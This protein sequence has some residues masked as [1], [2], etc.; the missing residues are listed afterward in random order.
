MKAMILAAGKGTRL[1]TI[2]DTMPKAL[3]DIN[4][5]SALQ[6]AVEKCVSYGFN[7]IIVNVHHFADLVEDEAARLRKLG[8]SIRLSDERE[9]L[10]DTGGGLF[11]ARNFFDNTPFLL[12]NVDI[13]T[14]LDLAVFFDFHKKR[15]CIS[16]LAVGNRNSDRVFL[17]NRKGILNG[18]RNKSTGEEIILT[19][20]SEELSEIA[21]LGL[22]IIDPDIFKY[23]NKGVYSMTSLYLK[24]A[25]SHKI[26]A[27]TY[28][29]GYWF[30]IGTP[31][32]LESVRDFMRR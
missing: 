3:V 18:W 28:D 10:L 4:G 8:Y 16:T 5:K 21:F 19:G 13:V 24:L 15:K 17:I 30:D 1:G 6:L 9:I 32:N 11:N 14:D 7:E 23:M 2:T 22:H 12:Y 27:F 25:S 26:C 20:L 31:E 29:N